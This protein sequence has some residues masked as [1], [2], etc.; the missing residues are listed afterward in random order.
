MMVADV[1][2]A[3]MKRMLR[4]RI[5]EDQAANFDEERHQG[6]LVHIAPGEMVAAGHVIEFVAEVAVPIVEVEVKQEICECKEEN[7]DHPARQKRLLFNM[8]SRPLISS[9][10]HWRLCRDAQVP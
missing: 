8:E 5:A 4:R 10:F 2:T 3:G 1:A 9:D 6:R 7:A